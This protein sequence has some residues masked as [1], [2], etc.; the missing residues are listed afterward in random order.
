MT[1]NRSV[2]R[3]NEVSLYRVGNKEQMNL[4]KSLK[5]IGKIIA[6]GHRKE[7][8]V[9]THEIYKQ[10][11]EMLRSHVFKKCHPLAIQCRVV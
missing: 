7:P 3:S 6:T 11:L 5:S 1:N 4:F 10:P 8:N 9:I 2:I